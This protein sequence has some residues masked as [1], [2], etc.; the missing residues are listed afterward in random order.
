MFLSSAI[1]FPRIRK[2]IKIGT[3]V[4]E[5]IAP[6]IIANDFVNAKGVNNLPSCPVKAKI[7]KN[8]TTTKIKAKK[9]GRPTCFADFM[10]I[11]ILSSF[12]IFSVNLA[13]II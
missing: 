10:I 13:Y 3:R 1:I 2:T 11:W 5:R 8:E 12:E 6:V 4:I 9:I 7:G